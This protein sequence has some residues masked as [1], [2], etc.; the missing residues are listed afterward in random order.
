MLD[1]L[2]LFMEG[3]SLCLLEKYKLPLI[4]FEKLNSFNLARVRPAAPNSS[5][6]S[7]LNLLNQLSHLNIKSLQS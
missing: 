4:Y 7:L 3:G 2:S 6:S 5:H 1:H